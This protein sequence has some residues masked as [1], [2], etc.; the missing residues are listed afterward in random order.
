MRVNRNSYLLPASHRKG[1]DKMKFYSS[2]YDPKFGFVL[3]SD[4]GLFL[5]NEKEM[6]ENIPIH[7]ATKMSQVSPTYL[8]QYGSSHLRSELTRMGYLV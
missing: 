4:R 8:A 7:K 2:Y 1:D 3:N 6:D 5:V